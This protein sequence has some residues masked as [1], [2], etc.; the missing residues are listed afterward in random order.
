MIID[1]E[2]PQPLVDIRPT[3]GER[4]P[5][6]SFWRR[7]TPMA[8]TLTVDPLLY[9]LTTTPCTFRNISYSN[10]FWVEPEQSHTP[11]LVS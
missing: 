2:G 10:E 5:D 4:T 8:T 1:P 9:I 7:E 11:N 6:T 3:P